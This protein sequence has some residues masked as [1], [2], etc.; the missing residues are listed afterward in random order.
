MSRSWRRTQL[1]LLYI[2]IHCYL[3][4]WKLGFEKTSNSW[5]L[6]MGR[7]KKLILLVCWQCEHII[8]LSIWFNG[9]K[10]LIFFLSFPFPFHWYKI[11]WKRFHFHF[12][13]DL[14]AWRFKLW[15]IQGIDYIDDKSSYQIVML[16]WARS[17]FKTF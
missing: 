6:T 8:S 9:G 5:G 17:G 15:S 7:M 4:V 3:R 2:S 10:G 16:A 14:V 13:F 1:L 12:S 11:F